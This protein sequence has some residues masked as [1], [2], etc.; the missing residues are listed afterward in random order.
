MRNGGKQRKEAFCEYAIYTFLFFTCLAELSY[1]N[2]NA[3]T[4]C[5]GIISQHNRKGN[6]RLQSSST[7]AQRCEIYYFFRLCY[8]LNGK[9]E[10]KKKGFLLHYF[11][12]VVVVKLSEGCAW[13]GTLIK[14][15]APAAEFA[16]CTAGGLQE[17]P[18]QITAYL[19]RVT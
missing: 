10:K 1:F 17:S 5:C 3:G 16:S 6:P 14:I 15:F 7:C 12:V 13:P 19:G 11:L 4:A 9:K 8:F 18:I 2:L